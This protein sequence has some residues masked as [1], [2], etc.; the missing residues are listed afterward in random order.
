[1]NAVS[2]GWW[3]DLVYQ[4]NDADH[5]VLKDATEGENRARITSGIITGLYILGDDFSVDGDASAKSRS[6]SL[7]TREEINNVATGVA[8]RPVEGN[9]E[10]SENQFVRLNE[11][12]SCDYAVFNYSDEE[13]AFLLQYETNGFNQW[14]AAQTLLERILLNGHD[15]QTYLDAIQKTLPFVIAKDPLLASRLFDV[16]AE[17][18]L[19]SRIDQNYQP[20]VVQSKRN[21]LLDTFAREMGTFWKETYQALDPELQNEFSQAMGERA[22]KN[23]A[24]S[25][26]ARQGDA[27]AFTWA[28]AQYQTTRNMSE[29]LG[30]LK[31]LVWNDAPQAQA[32]LD[33]FYNRFNDEPLAL[34][35]WFML[36]AAHPKATAQTIQYLTSHA[37]YD[38]GTP[39]RIRAVSGGLNANP[40][41]TWSFGV[42]HFIELAQ[43]LDE[44]NPIVG[45]RMLQVLSRWYTLA[46]P[47]RSTV[48]QQLQDLKAQVKSKNVAETLNSMLSV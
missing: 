4:Y 23:I 24:L 21:A 14:Q 11:D 19:G 7:L 18:Y 8:F 28:E 16:P 41:N 29:R 42:Q 26:M 45:S 27:D 30:A 37:D 36:Q 15:A 34:D 1:M 35:Q 5:I 40:V 33:D 12:G 20:E 6:L 38:L 10:A 3:Q 39:N 43:Y 31:V 48:Q 44:K 47:Q 46:E 9:G 22:L 13:L 25:Y 2:Y 17:G 32:C